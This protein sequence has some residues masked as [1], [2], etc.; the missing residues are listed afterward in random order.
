MKPREQ[1][2]DLIPEKFKQNWQELQEVKHKRR[3]LFPVVGQPVDTMIL[4]T[5]P[6]L[7][8]ADIAAGKAEEE[9]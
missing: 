4:C 8:V 5:D 6:N 9:A 2:I 3:I 1:L 7:T